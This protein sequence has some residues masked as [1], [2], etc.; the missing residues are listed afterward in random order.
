[1]LTLVFLVRNNFFITKDVIVIIIFIIVIL[2]T[3]VSIRKKNHSYKSIIS[4]PYYIIV[5]HKL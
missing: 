1:M 5:Y 4:T 3:Y 2:H